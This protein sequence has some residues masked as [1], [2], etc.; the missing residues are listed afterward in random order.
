MKYAAIG[1]IAWILRRSDDALTYDCSTEDGREAQ[2]SIKSELEGGKVA[3]SVIFWDLGITDAIT[4][5]A[6]TYQGNLVIP[7]APRTGVD[8]SKAVESDD[9]YAKQEK[10][11]DLKDKGIITEEEFQTEK[12]QLLGEN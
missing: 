7:V 5:K 12:K 3:A 11:S 8:K 1:R 4:D 2:G 6:R 9:V 10:L